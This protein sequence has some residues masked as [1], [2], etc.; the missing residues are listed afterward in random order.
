MRMN[1]RS[2]NGVLKKLF[3]ALQKEGIIKVNID[4]LNIEVLSLDSISVKVHPNGTG[5]LK[6]AGNKVLEGQE[7]GLT[8]KIYMVTS[9]DRTVVKFSLIGENRHDAPAGRD[10]LNE[11]IIKE[12]GFLLMDRAY[13][14]NKTHNKMLEQGF[15]PVVP[16]KK[17]STDPWEYDKELYKCRNEIE[18]FFRCLVRESFHSNGSSFYK[19]LDLTKNRLIITHYC[20]L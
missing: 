1:R 13:K 18:R 19:S 10:L 12:D 20:F 14:G 2:K 3:E 4:K 6:K 9:S 15:T 7:G 8:T 5:S 17:N 16:Q 11:I